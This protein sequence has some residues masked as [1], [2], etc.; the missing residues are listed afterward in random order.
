M[1]ELEFRHPDEDT[2]FILRLHHRSDAYG[3]FTTN[4]GSNA[5]VF[6]LKRRL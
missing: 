6:G 2:T 3:L 1:G 5:L 4:S